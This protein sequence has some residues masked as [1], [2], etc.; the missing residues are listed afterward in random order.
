MLHLKEFRGERNI[1]AGQ[2]VE[3]LRA[4]YPKMDKHLYSKLEHPEDYGC[5]LMNEAEQLLEEAFQ[6]TTLE[7]HRP[8]RRK[9]LRAML[10]R[11]SNT[12]YERLQHKFHADGFE[13]IQAGLEYLTDKYLN[14]NKGEEK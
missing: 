6:K 4:K 10:F 12:K 13:T 8:D 14:E 5:R 9:R 1:T 3:V 2:V 11:P 7:A